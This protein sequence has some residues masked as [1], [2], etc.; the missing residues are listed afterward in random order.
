MLLI[1]IT[2]SYNKIIIMVNKEVKTI[3]PEVEDLLYKVKIIDE[4]KVIKTL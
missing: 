4:L 3:L 2:D 1:I